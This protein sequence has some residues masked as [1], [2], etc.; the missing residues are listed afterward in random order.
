MFGPKPPSQYKHG[1]TVGGSFTPEYSSWA[2][3]RGRCQAGKP[4]TERGIKV[5]DR[6]LNSFQ[7][8]LADMGRRPSRSHTIERVDNNGNYE[9]GN[10]IWATMAVQAQN[11][12]SNRPVTI[13]GETKN[14]NQWAKAAGIP[15]GIIRWRIRRGWPQGQWLKTVNWERVVK[16]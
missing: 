8:F 15:E 11:K 5:C 10:C 6:W 9:P 2:L 4:Y 3:M 12:R 1:G 16:S 14:L 13:N 7:N